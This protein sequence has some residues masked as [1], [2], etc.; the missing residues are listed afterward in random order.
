MAVLVIPPVNQGAYKNKK[1]WFRL[2]H[3]YK[4][5]EP[6][7]ATPRKNAGSGYCTGNR[8]ASNSKKKRLFRS[9]LGL[10]PVKVSILLLSGFVVW[11]FLCYVRVLF[12]AV[13]AKC[14]FLII[15]IVVF[16]FWG[17]V[18]FLLFPVW[19]GDMFI[20]LPL[21]RFFLFLGAGA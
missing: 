13:W 2:L 4:I 18:I 10:R 7:I 3:R 19:A 14:F 8:G 9:G 11:P 5:P 16:C 1:M 12:V 21:G 17:G 20:S 15:I 6:V